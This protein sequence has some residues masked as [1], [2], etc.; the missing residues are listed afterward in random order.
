MV[1]DILIQNKIEMTRFDFT[2]PVHSIWI[3]AEM[4]ENLGGMVLVYNPS[5]RLCG[6]ITLGSNFI[7]EIYISDEVCTLNGLYHKLFSGSYTFMIIP[8]YDISKEEA[9]IR[10]T[11]EI[12]LHKTYEEKYCQLNLRE[13]EP[14]F[15]EV[16]DLAHRYYK[17]DFHGHTIFSDGHN[18]ILEAAEILKRQG[19]DF[20]A[21]TE[22]NSMAFGT[23][24]L[25]CL[26]IPS[27]ELTL[28]IGHI[29][30][31]GVRDLASFYEQLQKTTNYEKIL[32]LVTDFFSPGS[33]LSLNHMFLIPWQFTYG[34]FD[35]SVLN[36]IE[37]ICDPTY[38]TAPEANDRAAAFL[39]FLWDRGYRIY[40]IGGSDSHNKPEELYEGSAEPSIYGDPATYV[41]CKGLSVQNVLEGIQGGHCYT[42]RYV[43]LDIRIN[44]GR[45]LP[46]DCVGAEEEVIT[47][48]I[49]IEN[50]TKPLV[51]RFILN[52]SIIEEILL[53]ENRDSVKY[54]L[55]NLEES[56]W[57]R[58]GI[59]DREGH[60]VAYVN[61]VYH[62]PS[63][64]RKNSFKILLDEFGELYD[65]GCIV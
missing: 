60:V 49:G 63:E 52:G 37:V 8:F 23:A 6:L 50:I 25:P 64:L 19:M 57:L 16:T 3:K 32:E 35:L 20:M 18:S 53:K 27:F 17:G 38:G 13:E 34:E 43:T 54:S 4:K 9:E 11:A 10:L 12:N 36:T 2:E 44:E 31:H 40:G 29:N 24:S 41:Y 58:F 47:F 56:W 14:S 51:G 21:F 26:S 55:K 22:H 65:K 62:N 42:A 28:P 61:P 5:C 1:K 45:Y 7:N 33:N 15:T 48:E 46:G 30:I 59:Y 39:D